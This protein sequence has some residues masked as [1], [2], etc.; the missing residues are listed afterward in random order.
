MSEA[1]TKSQGDCEA[2][3]TSVGLPYVERTRIADDRMVGQDVFLIISES[4]GQSGL[5]VHNPDKLHEVRSIS[6]RYSR[7][8]IVCTFHVPF[9]QL[10]LGQD[11]GFELSAEYADALKI[12]A[13]DLKRTKDS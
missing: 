13:P 6:G 11:S 9:Q 2:S 1:V 8:Q 4:I 5:D 3:T 10:A 7:L 12:L